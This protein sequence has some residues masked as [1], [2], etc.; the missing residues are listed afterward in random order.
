MAAI[1]SNEGNRWN[2][3]GFNLTKRDALSSVYKITMPVMLHVCKFLMICNIQI[4]A[5]SCMLEYHDQLPWLPCHWILQNIIYRNT[6][7][8]F[9]PVIV[10]MAPS[11]LSIS[12]NNRTICYLLTFLFNMSASDDTIHCNKN[13]TQEELQNYIKRKKLWAL[14]KNIVIPWNIV[15]M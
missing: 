13:C 3:L 11:R 14:S 2:I 1:Y 4:D 15:T 10:L 5:S 6:K 9:V 7:S 8:F 12:Q